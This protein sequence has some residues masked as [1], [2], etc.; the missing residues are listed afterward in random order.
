MRRLYMIFY[1]MVK[2]D[3]TN[4]VHSRTTYLLEIFLTLIFIALSEVILGLINLRLGNF[5][6]YIL[7]LLP[8]PFAA[9]L[10]IKKNFTEE[11]GKYIVQ[12][13]S[14]HVKKRRIYLALLAIGLYIS[15]FLSIIVCGMAMSYLF[16]LHG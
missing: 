7:I 15:A 4:T 14:E 11:K 3:G 6:Y 2:D 12:N 1:C 13:F 10:L 16:S 8:S 5:F 9:Y